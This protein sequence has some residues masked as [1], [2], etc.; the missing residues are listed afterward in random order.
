MGLRLHAGLTQNDSEDDKQ[1][2]VRVLEFRQGDEISGKV[3]RREV[4]EV[5]AAALGNPAAVDKTFEVL[6][7]ANARK[8]LLLF[9][10]RF[11]VKKFAYYNSYRNQQIDKLGEKKGGES[12]EVEALQ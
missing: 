9:H 7:P 1:Q 11:L 6:F 4:A 5:V 3:S 10:R 2:V 12:Y 8:H